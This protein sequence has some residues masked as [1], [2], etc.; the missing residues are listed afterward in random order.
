MAL[1][2]LEGVLDGLELGQRHAERL[3]DL[4]GEDVGG[5]QV[6]GVVQALV[7]EPEQVERELVAGR[8]LV[9]VV[10]L[11]PVR[12][13]RPLSVA[14][15]VARYEVLEVGDG[16]RVGLE[17]EVLVRPQVVDPERR[18]PRG[19][20]GRLPVEEQDVGLDALG[21][22]DARREPEQRVEVVL[23]Q[24][25]LANA[26]AGPALEEHVV[27]DHDGRPAPRRA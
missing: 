9:V 26:L 20:T 19:L 23:L 10:A 8:D 5:R 7:A 4:G 18:R 21:V 25:A 6:V 24:E 2:G 12:L 14:R 1:L 17:R 27:G 22:E 11:E 3:D 16:E 15:S 13:F